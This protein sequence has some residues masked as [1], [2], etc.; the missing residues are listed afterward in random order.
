M[1]SDALRPAPGARD[2]LTDRPENKM[3][4]VMISAPKMDLVV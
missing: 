1:T 2:R 4:F 3:K